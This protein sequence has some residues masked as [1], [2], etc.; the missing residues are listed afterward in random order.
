[1][2][3]GT[4]NFKSTQESRAPGFPR[5]ITQ[6]PTYPFSS[7]NPFC[8]TTSAASMPFLVATGVRVCQGFNNLSFKSGPEEGAGS[9]RLQRNTGN[10]RDCALMPGTRD[11]ISWQGVARSLPFL[12]TIPQAP[13][14]LRTS[15]NASVR[16]SVYTFI[17]V[18][19]QL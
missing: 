5:A 3:R 16:G 6:S 17:A 10:N 11:R 1:M 2:K 15:K 18:S 9:K 7:C 13:A 12:A 14:R 19:P 8:K 4:S